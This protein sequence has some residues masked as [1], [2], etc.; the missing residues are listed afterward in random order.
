MMLVARRKSDQNVAAMDPWTV[1][2][3]AAGLAAG[4]VGISFTKSMIA[5][6]AYEVFEHGAERTEWGQKLFKTEGPENMANMIADL[7]VFGVGH[8][9]GKWWNTT[10]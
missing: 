2:H 8:Q 10:G 7:I 4:L 6:T 5:A 1:V 3:L 9:L